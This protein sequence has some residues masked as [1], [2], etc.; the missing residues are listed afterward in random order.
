MMKAIVY[1]KGKGLVFE[2][3]PVPEPGPGQVL[4][5]L[6]NTGFCGSDHTIVVHDY[7]PDGHILG[8][9]VSG[10]V[11]KVGA[12]V[13]GIPLGARV[14]VRPNYCGQCRE[15]L[16]GRQVLCR[17]KR[18]SIG[19][20]DLPGGF[21]Q[22]LIAFP[23]MLIQIPESVDSRNAALAEVYATSLHAI[24][25]AGVYKGSALVMGGGPIGLALVDLLGNYEFETICL[26]EPVAAKRDLSFKMGATHGI[27]PL[28]ESLPDLTMGLTDN[29]G[30]D[31]IFECSGVV[32]NIHSSSN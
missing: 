5:Q 13:D 32:S 2:Q 30:F 27:D 11:V 7:V 31:V 1:R 21:A 23:D 22:Y 8:H 29:R 26:S 24:K 20:G 16:T 15:C 10:I 6:V 25:R 9:E 14:C 19:T 17:T 12:D 28:S 18:R 4:I 3:T